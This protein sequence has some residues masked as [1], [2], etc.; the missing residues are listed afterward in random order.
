MRLFFTAALACAALS[1]SAQG[2]SAQTLSG[3][4]APSFSLPDSSFTQHDI[5]DYRGRWLIIDFMKTDC[6]H[7]KALTKTLETVKAKYG[8][9]IAILSVV[10]PPDNMAT[11]ARYIADNHVTA[12]IVFDGSQVAASYFKITPTNGGHFDTPHW[13]AI[14]PSGMIAHDWGQPSAD[15]AEWTKQL[16][17][18][19]A[20]RK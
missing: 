20:A 4:R 2:L 3:R 12:P 5:L 1:L 7:C 13:F 16:D 17:T 9:K 8:E 14:D 10:V 18:L 6:P 15:S 19:I 11:V